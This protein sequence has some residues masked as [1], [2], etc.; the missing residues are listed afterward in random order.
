MSKPKRLE[1]DLENNVLFGVCGGI[2]NYFE[3]DATMIRVVWVGLVLFYGLLSSVMFFVST[4]AMFIFGALSALLIKLYFVCAL[5]MPEYLLSPTKIFF[6]VLAMLVGIGFI[7]STVFNSEGPFMI[8]VLVSGFFIA[9]W[10]LIK[11]FSNY[12][13]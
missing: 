1:R 5:A 3:N 13:K 6:V 9:V 7:L 8:T 11:L 12:K 4:V 10:G 2:A